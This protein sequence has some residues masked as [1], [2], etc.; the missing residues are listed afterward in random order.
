MAPKKP[1]PGRVALRLTKDEYAEARSFIL[2]VI[3]SAGLK[4]PTRA[5]V[6]WAKLPGEARYGTFLATKGKG[7]MWTR[8]PRNPRLFL[9]VVRPKPTAHNRNVHNYVP[10]HGVRLAVAALAELAPDAFNCHPISTGNQMPKWWPSFTTR[11]FVSIQRR[12]GWRPYMIEVYG[13]RES[14]VS[15]IVEALQENKILTLRKVET[16][17]EALRRFLHSAKA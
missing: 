16:A 14:F 11:Q 7:L 2:A 5:G 3:E 4:N 10:R 9:E 15:D 1:K 8:P 17:R 13:S 12:R 6:A